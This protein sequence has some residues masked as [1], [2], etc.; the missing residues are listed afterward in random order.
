MTIFFNWTAEDFTHAWDGKPF[1]FTAGEIYR[2]VITDVNGDDMLLTPVIAEH[3]A[4]H[5]SD[6]AMITENIAPGRLDEKERFIAK[7]LEAPEEVKVAKVEPKATTKKE[8]I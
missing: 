2:K 3:F 8:I 5:L 6:K 1:T 4:K 7:A